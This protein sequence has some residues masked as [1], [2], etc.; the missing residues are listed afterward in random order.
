[1]GEALCSARKRPRRLPRVRRSTA[2]GT[3]N[4]WAEREGK[5]PGTGARRWRG[6]RA[7]TGCAPLDNGPAQRCP[8][9]G[10]ASRASQPKPEPVRARRGR[11]VAVI[12]VVIPQRAMA[13]SA[14]PADGRGDSPGS[15]AGDGKR[16]ET[17]SPKTPRIRAPEPRPRV[18]AKRAL[19]LGPPSAKSRAARW[20]NSGKMGEITRSN[21]ARLAVR[22]GGIGRNLLEVH[23]GA[24]GAGAPART[25]LSLPEDHSGARRRRSARESPPV[26]AGAG[27]VVRNGQF[28][29]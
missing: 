11:A 7:F 23:A 22:M 19:E 18:S 16:L 10:R 12:L 6:G 21:F 1:M 26:L 24:V 28:R 20:A 9:R 29:E 14:C 3:G 8:P 17:V 25:R 4:A 27:L 15:R 2:T 13:S 5:R